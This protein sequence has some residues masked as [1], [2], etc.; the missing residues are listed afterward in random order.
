MAGTAAATSFPSDLRAMPSTPGMFSSRATTE[1]VTALE[2]SENVTYRTLVR[3]RSVKSVNFWKE[4]K[5]K[6]ESVAGAQK[7]QLIG[8]N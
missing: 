4:V 2:K 6:R 1:T 5:T 3:E 8:I 7:F